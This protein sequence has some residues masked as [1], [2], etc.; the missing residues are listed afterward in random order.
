MELASH[1]L[2]PTPALR[3]KWF[4]RWKE[5]KKKKKRLF[6][7]SAPD[8]A[9]VENPVRRLLHSGRAKAAEVARIGAAPRAGA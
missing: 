2:G 5:T 8:M 1:L 3:E 4:A 9:L 6:V 7:L